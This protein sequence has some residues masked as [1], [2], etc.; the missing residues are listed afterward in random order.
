MF[1]WPALWS[2]WKTGLCQDRHPQIQV[3]A[4]QYLTMNILI[5][6]CRRS[7]ESKSCTLSF[8]A[9][10]GLLPCTVYANG[11]AGP[12]GT[13]GTLPDP[14]HYLPC[15]EAVAAGGGSPATHLWCINNHRYYVCEWK[16]K[17]IKWNIPSRLTVELEMQK[18][19]TEATSNTNVNS[20]MDWQT[21]DAVF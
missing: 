3:S 4:P 2:G 13:P 17:M 6:S 15:E 19:V 14:I 20:N 21:G 18:E 12:R 9:G 11:L 16:W 10:P 8:Q 5:L 7:L 1:S